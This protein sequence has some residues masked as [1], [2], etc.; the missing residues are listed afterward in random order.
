MNTVFASLIEDDG[1][2]V[3]T[4]KNKD[5]GSKKGGS[6]IEPK[7]SFSAEGSK[8][9]DNRSKGAATGGHK[10]KERL[11]GRPTKTKSDGTSRNRQFDRTGN[12]GG[13]RKKGA[14]PGGWG[15]PQKD[16]TAAEK[17]GVSDEDDDEDDDEEVEGGDDAE[18]EFVPPAIFTYDDFLKRQAEGSKNKAFFGAQSERSVNASDYTGMKSNENQEEEY[19]KKTY[20]KTQREKK[21]QRSMKAKAVGGDFGIAIDRPPR[22]FG[23]RDNRDRGDGD[24]RRSNNGGRGGRGRGDRR[25]DRAGGRGGR[26]GRGINILDT[27]A[28]PTLG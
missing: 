15:N 27:K 11:Q 3:K 5:S 2:A 28:F 9:V 14:G 8:K 19:M 6:S 16:A 21:A 18:E 10:N 20:G 24:N 17:N 26:G 22:D 23:D 1:P 13:A 25:D 12:A 7:V 4:P